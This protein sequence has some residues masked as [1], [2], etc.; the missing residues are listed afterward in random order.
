MKKSFLRLTALL[1]SFTLL[2]CGCASSPDHAPDAQKEAGD[3][4]RI[5]ST[6]VA[7]CEILDA[8]EYDDVIGVPVTEFDLPARYA[9][10][11]KIGAPMSPDLEKITQLSP[12]LVLSP[13]S[14]E[15]DLSVKYTNA[16][17]NAGFLDLSN[18]DGMYDAIV[19]LGELLGREAQAQKLLAERD[20]FLKGFTFDAEETPSILL[21]MAFPDGFYLIATENSYVGNLVKLAGGKNVYGND[22]KGDENGFVNINAED[23]VQRDADYILVFAHYGEQAAFDYMQHEF[24]TNKTWQYFDAVQ[25]GRV[26][27]LPRATFGMSASLSWTEGLDYLKPLLHP[28]D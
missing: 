9:G 26:I 10:A 15:G 27:Y 2:L 4:P 23:I 3:T 18:V 21:L 24:E 16:A 11:E 12:D 28:G 22:Y 19:S 7:I 20:A 14:L 17:L 8:L 25:N 5:V 1:C 13:Q 6:S